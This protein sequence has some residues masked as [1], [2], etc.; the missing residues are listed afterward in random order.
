MRSYIHDH[1]TKTCNNGEITVNLCYCQSLIGIYCLFGTENI[2]HSHFRPLF[3]GQC[4]ADNIFKC[5]LLVWN[6]YILISWYFLIS[7]LTYWCLLLRVELT[8]N[9]HWVRQQIKTWTSDESVSMMKICITKPQW[10]KA[11][12]NWV[13][14]GCC[15]KLVPEACI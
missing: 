9:K 10:V 12:Q 8:I 5:N 2:P 7:W 11:V 13:R 14:L 3:N 1:F 6:I 4:S 15:K